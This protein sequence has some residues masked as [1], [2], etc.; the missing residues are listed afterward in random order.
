M[1]DPQQ[2]LDALR[3]SLAGARR[4]EVPVAQL[5]STWRSLG[6]TLTALPPRYGEVLASLLMQL[7]SGSLFTEESCSFSQQDL[8]DSLGV[9]LDKARAASGRA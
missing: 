3:D 7:E 9:W 1:T 5:V 2:T 8:L 4:G 6:S